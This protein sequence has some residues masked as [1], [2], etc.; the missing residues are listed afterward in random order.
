LDNGANINHQNNKG[1]TALMLAAWQGH[2]D[3]VQL[4]L[5]RRA[6]IRL[7][8]TINRKIYGR[9]PFRT[10]DTACKWNENVDNI[11]PSCD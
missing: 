10:G 3:V 6:N 8:V 1:E 7:K 9:P 5:D 4:L 11:I 2:K